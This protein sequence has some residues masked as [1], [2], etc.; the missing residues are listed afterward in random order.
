MSK[1]MEERMAAVPKTP[2]KSDVTRKSGPPKFVSLAN[3]VL[4]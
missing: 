2:A 1:V 4:F 3:A